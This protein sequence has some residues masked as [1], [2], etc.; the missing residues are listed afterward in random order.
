MEFYDGTNWQVAGTTFTL[1]RDDQWTG[2]GS[3]YYYTLSGA[4][5]TNGTIVTINGVTQVPGTAYSVTGANLVFTETPA[6]GDLIDARSFTTTSTVGQIATGYSSFDAQANFANITAGTSAATV[7]VSVAS[8]GV[9]NL[10]NGTKT[11]YSSANTTVSNTNLT[12][13]D[14]FSANSYTSAKYIVSM[15]QSSTAN[16]QAMEALLVQNRNNA[17]IT[18]YG[19]INTGNSMGTLAANVDLTA[20]WTVNMWLIPNAGTAISNVKVYTTYI[21]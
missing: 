21:A 20:A 7:R 11:A 14:S 12:L 9:L 3:A 1:V 2:D 8:N 19:V 15:A 6:P 13:L 10:V 4:S 17:Y 16:V 5:T 18:T